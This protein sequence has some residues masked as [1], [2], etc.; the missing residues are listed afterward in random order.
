MSPFIYVMDEESRDELL[1]MGY[2][3]IRSDDVAHVWVF[4]DPTRLQFTKEL[5][6]P[7]IMSASFVL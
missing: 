7:H 5:K 3:L 4:D 2:K 6:V 1:A